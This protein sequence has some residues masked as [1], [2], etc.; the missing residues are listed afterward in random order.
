[1]DKAKFNKILGAYIK[2]KRLE[3]GWTQS[4]LADKLGNNFQNISRIERGEISPT[5]YWCSLLA[6]AFEMSLADFI[7]DA[8]RDS[9]ESI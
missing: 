2:N 6:K 8:F 3:K 4:D 1:M 5:L 7:N 9:K